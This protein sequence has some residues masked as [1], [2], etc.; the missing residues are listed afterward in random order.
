MK[1]QWDD[2][3]NTG[4]SVID[5]QHQKLL[6][7][8][9]DLGDAMRLGKSKDVLE[10]VLTVLVE[11]TATHFTQEEG[12]MSRASYDGLEKHKQE[13][14][15]FIKK[16]SDYGT[17]VKSGSA[18]VSVDMMSFLSKWLIQHI[19]GADRQY[20]PAVRGKSIT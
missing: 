18:L 16:I 12:L 10:D 11:Y 7:L 5:Q 3:W 1:I 20:V 8:V 15:G 2:S 9:N 13:H 6:N 19:K 14:A 17:R 4:I